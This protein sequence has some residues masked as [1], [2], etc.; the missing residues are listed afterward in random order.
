MTLRIFSLQAT[1]HIPKKLALT[2]KLDMKRVEMT[3]IN[4]HLFKLRMNVNLSSNVLGKY[5]KCG[6]K[7]TYKF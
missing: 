4:G 1:K 5:N 7:M 3:Q 2:G 6:I